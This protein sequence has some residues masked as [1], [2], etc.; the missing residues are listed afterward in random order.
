MLPQGVDNKDGG[1]EVRAYPI[2]ENI[3]RKMLLLFFSMHKYY[4]TLT[5]VLMP[6]CD[7]ADE[8]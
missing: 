5:L 3:D 1:S 6:R 2:C 7:L 4:W 8:L